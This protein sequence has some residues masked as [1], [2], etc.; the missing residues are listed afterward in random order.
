MII[1]YQSFH[2]NKTLMTTV[3]AGRLTPHAKVA[4]QTRT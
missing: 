4:V 2:R 1:L 3:C